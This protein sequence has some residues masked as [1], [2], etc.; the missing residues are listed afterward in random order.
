MPLTYK[1]PECDRDW[2]PG[3]KRTT[4][5]YMYVKDFVNFGFIFFVSRFRDQHPLT[6]LRK[7]RY[8]LRDSFIISLSPIISEEGKGSNDTIR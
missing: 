5:K 7:P 2:W 1:E 6:D 3:D 4:G 8:C